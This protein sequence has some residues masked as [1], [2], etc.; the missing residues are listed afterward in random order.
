M[1]TWIVLATTVG[2][3]LIGAAALTWL[4]RD[5]DEPSRAFPTLAPEDPGPIH[6]HGLG[7]NPAD[8]SLYI[9]THTG[10]YRTEPG[11][12]RAERVTDRFQDTMG[13][14]VAGP[15]RFLGSGH[16]DLRDELPPLLGLIRS[17]DAGRSWEPVSLLGE[18]DFHILRSAGRRVYGFDSSNQRL[19]L[20]RDGGKTW[21][22]R[23]H[24]EPLVDLAPDP[25]GARRLVASGETGLHASRD[26]GRTW[27]PLGGSPSLLAWPAKGALFRIDGVGAVG[28]SP[29][30]GRRWRPRGEIGGQP[31]AFLAQGSRE[32]YAA[33][34]DGTVK[35]S[36][37]GGRT[38]EL[39]SAP[40]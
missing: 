37:D 3:V 10:L 30:G 15:D 40:D 16:P 5:D 36:T 18:A 28:V 31:A 39:R 17:E 8:G 32:L 24:P 19:M 23:S 2:V 4:G 27:R 38:W 11:E 13:F 14:A 25:D 7:I 35:R 21:I 12:T 26:E 33:L 1:K 9:A 29:D 34:H 20:S 22:R 6:V